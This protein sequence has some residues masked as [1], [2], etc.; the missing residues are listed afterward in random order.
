MADVIAPVV[1][2][3]APV[4]PE[5]VA[6]V[7]PAVPATVAVVPAVVVPE[8]TPAAEVVP[9]NW[10]PS[11]DT[12]IDSLAKGYLA[13]GNT[14]AQFQAIL[15]DVGTAGTLTESAK[16]ELHKT[17]GDMA[18]ALIPTIEEKAK[19]NLAWVATERTA[20]YKTAGGEAEFHKM[21][22]WAKDNLDAATRGYLS[23]GLELGGESAQLALGQLKQ[24]MIAKGATVTGTTHKVDG[25]AE[26]AGSYIGLAQ[27]VTE[28]AA[29]QRSGDVVAIAALK[30][31]A[32]ASMNQANAKGVVWR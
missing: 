14:T 16:L 21:Q 26:T 24:Q 25:Q 28:N 4:V 30:A 9:E 3:V 10:T 13:K 22:A 8:I 7:V 29:L 6:P 1:P 31:K 32:T 11:G 23:A 15:D 19:A 17:F 5:V 27:Y 2:V 12:F 20:V 18:D